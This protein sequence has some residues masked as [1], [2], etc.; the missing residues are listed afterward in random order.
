MLQNRM[1]IRVAADVSCGILFLT[2]GFVNIK[3]VQAGQK[4]LYL[5]FDDGPSA[6]YTPQILNV[7]RHESSNLFCFGVSVS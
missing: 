7:L 3:P 6:V 5:T 2:L 1:L 4:V